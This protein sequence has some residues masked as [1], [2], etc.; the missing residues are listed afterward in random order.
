MRRYWVY[1]L[2]CS[3][4]SLY[5]G[6]TVDLRKRVALHNAG[7]GSKYTRARVPVALAYSEAAPTLSGA[8]KREAE[9]KKLS[10]SAKLL[11]CSGKAARASYSVRWALRR[12]R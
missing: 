1:I 9:I 12:N 7:R 4:G 5:T 8:L 11:L 3:D 2:R 6:Y 10:R